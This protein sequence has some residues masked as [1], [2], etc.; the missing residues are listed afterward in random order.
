M[1][2]EQTFPPMR[3]RPLWGKRACSLINSLFTGSDVLPPGAE[4]DRGF[5]VQPHE[6]LVSHGI[7]N[8]VGNTAAGITLTRTWMVDK[9]MID[10]F[11]KTSLLVATVSALTNSLRITA[12][13][14]IASRKPQLH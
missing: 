6:H 2:W 14:F 7:V 5:A 11:A 3:L 4:I 13:M 1:V 12:P 9:K 8:A 10:G